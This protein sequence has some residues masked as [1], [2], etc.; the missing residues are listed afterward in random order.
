MIKYYL[1]NSTGYPGHTLDGN[2][3]RPAVDIRFERKT[4]G[5]AGFDLMANIGIART[6]EPGRRWFCHT[7]LYLEMPLGVEAQVRTRSGMARDHGIC[8]LN[9][10][11]TVDSDYRGEIGLTLI[12]LG[13]LPYVVHPGDRVAQLVFAPVLPYV[14]PASEYRLTEFQIVRVSSRDELSSTDRGTSGFGSTGR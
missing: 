8:V 14:L 7:G 3:N 6:I 12:N 13:E 2:F 11:G 9:A 4:A 5:A 10:P 1:E